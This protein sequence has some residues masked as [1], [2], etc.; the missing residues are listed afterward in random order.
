MRVLA[1]QPAE[2]GCDEVVD[3]LLKQLDELESSQLVSVC[4]EGLENETVVLSRGLDPHEDAAN[5]AAAVGQIDKA[6]SA[7]IVSLGRP[8]E[9]TVVLPSLRG[10]VFFCSEEP[11]NT[12]RE[13][14]RLLSEQ[15]ALAVDVAVQRCARER[16]L[17]TLRQEVK[18]LQRLAVIGRSTADI[19]HELNNPLG[20]IVAYSDRL[21]MTFQ[22][23]KDHQGELARVQKIQHAARRIHQFSRGINDFGRPQLR[24]DV[25]LCPSDIVR[26]ALDLCDHQSRVHS[27]AVRHVVC[28]ETLQILGAELPLTQVF[29][30][31]FDNA[32]QA[33]ADTG[34]E[35]LIEERRFQDCVQICVSDQGSG[36]PEEDRLRIFE[37]YFSTKSPAAGLGLGLSIVKRIVEEHGGTIEVIR[38]EQGGTTFQVHLP[39]STG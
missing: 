8:F 26:R 24:E 13:V 33:M 16:E 2:I 20:S 4:F 32:Y 6:G 38:R 21:A 1:N 5:L 23:S 18:H 7:P 10:F 35:L 12:S 15:L 27:V 17:S 3:E 36:V 39:L 34:G 29:V 31:L 37:P 25:L 14:L 11:E 30:N 9:E 28:D 19:V 22:E